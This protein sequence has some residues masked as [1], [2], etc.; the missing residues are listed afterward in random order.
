MTMEP[1]IVQRAYDTVARDYARELPDTR[2]DAGLDLAMLDEFITRVGDGSLLDA[3]CGA[4]RITRYLADRGCAVEGVDLSPGMIQQARAAHPDVNFAVASLEDL[5]HEDDSFD[6]VLLWYSIIHTPP[7]RQPDIFDEVA[8]V[9]RPGGHLLV[10]F[11]AG[12]G[13]RDVSGAYGRFG[14]DV[15]LERYLFSADEVAAWIAGS[16]GREVARLVRAADGAETQ[17][18]AVVLGQWAGQD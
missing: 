12:T 6:G 15:V 11:Q 13:V 17:A 14:H 4:G 5:P 9:L 1:E 10:G 2:A 18:Q 16:G 3:G 8:R 7:A